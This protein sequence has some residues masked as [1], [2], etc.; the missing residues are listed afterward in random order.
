[1][2][3]VTAKLILLVLYLA[4]LNVVQQTP[5]LF[6]SFTGLMVLGVVSYCGI[7]VVAH[8]VVDCY[9]LCRRL[10]PPAEQ[11]EARFS[12]TSAALAIE[13]EAR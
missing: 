10:S 13:T 9:R 6:S 12:A 8:A 4:T 11:K 2:K 7:I 1:M 3:T 5:N